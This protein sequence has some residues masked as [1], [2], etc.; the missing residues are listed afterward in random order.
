MHFTLL[1][2]GFELLVPFFDNDKLDLSAAFLDKFE[3]LLEDASV[4]S[5]VSSMVLLVAIE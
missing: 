3:V 5:F 2:E 4:L 1:E